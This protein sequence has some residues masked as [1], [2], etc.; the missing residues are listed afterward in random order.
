S[1]RSY[2]CQRGNIEN[3]QKPRRGER[4][5]QGRDTAKLSRKAPLREYGTCLLLLIFL[6]RKRNNGPFG[7]GGRRIQQ[8]PDWHLISSRLDAMWLLWRGLLLTLPDAKTLP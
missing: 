1:P 2:R 5:E 3:H 6:P 4:P 8:I 7:R